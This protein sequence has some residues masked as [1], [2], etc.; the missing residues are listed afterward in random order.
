MC[1]APSLALRR[2]AGEGTL[3]RRQQIRPL[4][5]EAAEVPPTYTPGFAAPEQ[6]ARKVEL[7]PWTD[8]YS[9]GATVYVR[10]VA[11]VR[12]GYG[13]QPVRRP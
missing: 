2:F 8:I 5:R 4:S 3:V 6:Y 10:D 13:I 11:Q 1:E 12:Q 9:V 7:G